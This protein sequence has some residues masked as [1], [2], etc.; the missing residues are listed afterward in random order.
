MP[1]TLKNKTV[2]GI[3]FPY[4]NVRR[5]NYLLVSLIC[6]ANEYNVLYE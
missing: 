2:S 4:S 6:L 5:F 1:K 3:P